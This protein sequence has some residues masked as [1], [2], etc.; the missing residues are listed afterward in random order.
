[1]V[2]MAMRYMWSAMLSPWRMEKR[3]HPSRGVVLRRV[4]RWKK[5][6]GVLLLV[7]YCWGSFDR[8]G[9][10]LV[11]QGLGVKHVGPFLE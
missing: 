2:M 10:L 7:W 9:L 3:R 11:W 1:M 5:G 4:R 6:I 8:T